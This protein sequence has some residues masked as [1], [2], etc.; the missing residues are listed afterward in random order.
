MAW[1]IRKGRCPA[2][3]EDQQAERFLYTHERLTGAG[4]QH[5]EVSNYAL[6][7]H[8][9]QHNRKYWHHIPYL[10]LGPSAHSF[11]WTGPD[12][13]R[14]WANVASLRQYLRAL[15][16]DRLPVAWSEELGV[17]ALR[18]EALLLGLRLQEG[19]DLQRLAN[20]YGWR[21]DPELLRRWIARGWAEYTGDRLRLTAQGWLLTDSL[22]LE[23]A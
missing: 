5:Y 6:P 12:R 18:T 8:E 23:C 14:R 11:R 10:G 1:A 2:P 4:Y 20:R 22:L 13:A 16:A 9:S 15:E 17:E 7:G 21:P 3:D 19:L